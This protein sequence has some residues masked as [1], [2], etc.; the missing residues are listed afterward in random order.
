MDLENLSNSEGNPGK[1][2]TFPRGQKRLGIA[3]KS[4]SLPESSLCCL[5][6][7]PQTA[8]NTSQHQLHQANG[9]NHHGNHATVLVKHNKKDSTTSSDW[10]RKKKSGSKSDGATPSNYDSDDQATDNLRGDFEHA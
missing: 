3:K 10:L 2:Y 8:N 1:T 7:Q 6:Q 4:Q 5:Q 9:P